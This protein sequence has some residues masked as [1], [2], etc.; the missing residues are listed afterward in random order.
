MVSLKADMK[1]L[2]QQINDVRQSV[3]RIDRNF[4]G[5]VER[6][7]TVEESTKNAHKRIGEL[8]ERVN[9]LGRK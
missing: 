1:Y 7:A 9:E 2:S 3:D 5:L 4:S 8:W 6:M